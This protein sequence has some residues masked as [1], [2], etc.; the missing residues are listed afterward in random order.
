MNV[1]TVQCTLYSCLDILDI[2]CFKKMQLFHSFKLKPLSFWLPKPGNAAWRRFYGG[3]H[4]R[5]GHVLCLRS[6]KKSR[7]LV[8][9]QVRKR[10]ST[11]THLSNLSYLLVLSSI[12]LHYLQSYLKEIH[13][14]LMDEL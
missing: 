2:L 1:T 5:W 13:C 4:P 6:W 12:S 14:K 9:I 11:S 3:H 8:K 7:N 10:N